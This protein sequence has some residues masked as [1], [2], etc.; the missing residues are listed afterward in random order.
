MELLFRDCRIFLPHLEV[1]ISIIFG[2]SLWFEQN[3]YHTWNNGLKI[4]LPVLNYRKGYKTWTAD[5]LDFLILS[6]HGS[7]R[8]MKQW[9]SHVSSNKGLLPKKI[10]SKKRISTPCPPL[11][12]LLIWNIFNCH[13]WTHY[14]WLS[15]QCTLQLSIRALNLNPTAQ[16]ISIKPNEF[17]IKYVSHHIWN[18][19][20]QSYQI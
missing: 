5:N 13:N 6:Y 3:R 1:N 16:S 7:N 14:I 8:H 17:A 10:C 18:I 9:W 4:T 12:P 15:R 19:F 20:P 2:N 11:A